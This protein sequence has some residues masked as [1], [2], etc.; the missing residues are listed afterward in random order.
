MNRTLGDV[1]PL[2]VERI[3]ETG[4]SAQEIAE[5][6]RES[7]EELGFGE[8]SHEPSSPRVAEVKAVLDELVLADDEE[9]ELE[10][11]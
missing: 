9:D 4:A 11:G 7:L 3:L 1:D 2:V 5:A 6:L 8:E 10:A